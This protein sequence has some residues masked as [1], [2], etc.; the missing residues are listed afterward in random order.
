MRMPAMR[1]GRMTNGST[2][3]LLIEDNPGDA[4]PV[5]L[6]R[7][8]AHSDVA[9]SGATRL[10]AGLSSMLVDAPAMV[11]LDLDLPDSH[12]AETYRKVLEQAPAVPVDVL[13][14]LED[15]EMA[16]SVVHQGV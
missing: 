10:S 12:G 13:S 14:G 3:I 6:R 9:V 11:L 8:D 15:E 7:G 16:A 5:R 4:D 2:H 1:G